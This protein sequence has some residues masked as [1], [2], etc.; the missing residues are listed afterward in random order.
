VCVYGCVVR[1]V[2]VQVLDFMCLFQ[3]VSLCVCDCV[4][5]VLV[6]LFDC[7]FSN[8]STCVCVF[9]FVYVF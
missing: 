8:V 6:Q 4:V 1:V 5:V 3:Y 2:L 7:M 9:D